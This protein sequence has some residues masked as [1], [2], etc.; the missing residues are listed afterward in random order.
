M[1]SKVW[2]YY[3]RLRPQR[4]RATMRDYVLEVNIATMGDDIELLLETVLNGIELL[5][6]VWSYYG[7]RL[8]YVH[9]G[10]ELQW[11]TMS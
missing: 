10:L 11:K 7:S 8:L 9:Y 5:W 2:S 1:S 6:E 3:G 4:N